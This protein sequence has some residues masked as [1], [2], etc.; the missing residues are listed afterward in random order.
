MDDNQPEMIPMPDPVGPD[1]RGAPP[2]SFTREVTPEEEANLLLGMMGSTYGELKKLD[3]SQVGG[4]SS[5]LRS[6]QMKKTLTESINQIRRSVPKP[7]PAPVPPQPLPPQPVPQPPKPEIPVEHHND[8][9]LTF[10][11]DIS[12]K[13][14]LFDKIEKLTVKV[15]NLG[16]KLDQIF[17]IV[18]K[19]KTAKKKTV[20]KEEV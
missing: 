17:E 5:H 19:P 2:E 7:P 11:F 10:N 20:K 6:D 18:N 9:Q 8:N 3:G 4:S 14:L 15:N 12:E 1:P 13:D 16:H